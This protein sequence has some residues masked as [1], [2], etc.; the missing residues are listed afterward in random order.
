MNLATDRYR[1][2]PIA[3]IGKFTFGFYTLT[4]L[5]LEKKNQITFYFLNLKIIF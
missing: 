4:L 2:K 1:N 5:D 3:Q